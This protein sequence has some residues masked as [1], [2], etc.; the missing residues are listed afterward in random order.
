MSIGPTEITLV[1]VV[2]VLLFGAS[3][4]PALARGAGSALRIFKTETK[5][6]LDDDTAPTQTTAGAPTANDS[7]ARTALPPPAEPPT[8]QGTGRHYRS[9]F[10]TRRGPPGT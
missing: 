1:L 5:G 7:A 3:K 2:I 4:L 8:G 10:A 9:V 6:L